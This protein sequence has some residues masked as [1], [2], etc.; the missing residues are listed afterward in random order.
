VA[1]RDKRIAFLPVEASDFIVTIAGRE[2]R[3]LSRVLG[4]FLAPLFRWRSRR[5][6]RHR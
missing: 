3:W 1:D 4:F 2:R 6:R 5:E